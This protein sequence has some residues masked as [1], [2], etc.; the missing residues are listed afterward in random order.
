MLNYYWTMVLHFLRGW[1]WATVIWGTNI[2]SRSRWPIEWRH[3][4]GWTWPPVIGWTSP[5]SYATSIWV[6]TTYN[7]RWWRWRPQ[8]WSNW[9]HG[10]SCRLRATSTN[11]WITLFWDI[12]EINLSEYNQIKKLTRKHTWKRAIRAKVP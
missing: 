8:R 1:R 2:T 7:R 12:Y 10:L 4:I 3:S 6:T 9:L 5:W 11:I